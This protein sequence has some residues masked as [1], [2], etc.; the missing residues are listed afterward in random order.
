MNRLIKPVLKLFALSVVIVLVLGSPAFAQRRLSVGDYYGAGPEGTIGRGTDRLPRGPSDWGGS[1]FPSA[2]L[3]YLS[4]SRSRGYY[5]A[6]TVPVQP[7]A[8]PYLTGQ[9]YSPGNGYRYP[10]YYNPVTRAYYY[11]P[12]VRR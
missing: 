2:N 1:G 7:A 12:A 6:S 9:F 5:A 3:P 4:Y 10:L 11:Y 8:P